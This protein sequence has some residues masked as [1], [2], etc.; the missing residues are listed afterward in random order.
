MIGLFQ[1]STREI[2]PSNGY[3]YS[4]SKKLFLWETE[5][6]EKSMR[7]DT[8]HLIP[9]S[10]PRPRC[11]PSSE[12]ERQIFPLQRQG[13]S[14]SRL[15]QTPL[16]ALAEQGAAKDPVKWTLGQTGSKRLKSGRQNKCN[17]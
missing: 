13:Q 1:P 2:N 6:E 15:A 5:G 16:I 12:G 3:L 10:A 7:S 9:L 14:H 4:P 11:L 8:L 17:S